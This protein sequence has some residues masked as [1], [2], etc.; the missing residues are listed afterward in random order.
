MQLHKYEEAD[1]TEKN[2][3]KIKNKQCIY[4]SVNAHTS[5]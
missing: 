5:V 2:K 1:G 4:I 3:N